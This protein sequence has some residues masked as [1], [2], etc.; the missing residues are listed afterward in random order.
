MVSSRT[1][2]FKLFAILF[3]WLPIILFPKR[4]IAR[5]I[6]AANIG[7]FWRKILPI[8]VIYDGRGAVD[9]EW[10][11]YDL[12][13]NDSIKKRSFDWEKEAI[14]K[15]D[16][17]IAVSNKLVTHWREKY[18][19]K[20]IQ[21]SVIPCTYNESVIVV[22]KSFQQKQEKI[23]GLSNKDIVLIYAGGKD[24]WQSVDLLDSL[25]FKVLEINEKIKVIF[26]TKPEIKQLNIFKKFQQRVFQIWVAPE[27]VYSM[28][29]LADYGLLIRENSETNK[30]SSPTK[31]GEYLAA[32]LKVI[33]SEN[34]G[35][36]S[37]NVKDNE[38]GFLLSSNSSEEVFK[39]LKKT[40]PEE[41]NELVKYALENLTKN[42]K[43]KSYSRVL[44]C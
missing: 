15:A 5:G 41:K 25:L 27:K 43:I 3:S 14:I 8:K 13:I 42:S 16:F 37:Q 34:I 28:L 11:E 22:D 24:P 17:R 4:V 18:Q 38:L 9:A 7:L 19:Y 31:F 35:D 32:G 12:G 29:S 44:N 30:V 26:L 2:W 36:Y 10:N 23:W 39:N 6:I 40:L 21:H 1:H 33:I 20:G